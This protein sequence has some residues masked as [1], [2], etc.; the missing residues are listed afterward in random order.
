MQR[1]NSIINF[2]APNIALLVSSINYK[3]KSLINELRIRK[4]QPLCAVINSKNYYIS[5]S[6][7]L[8]EGCDNAY[9]CTGQDVDDTF[10]NLTNHSVYAYE[11]QISL[12]YLPLPFGNRAGLSGN[13]NFVDGNY[14][15]LN[16][17]G[18]CIRIAREHKGCAKELIPVFYNEDS[19]CS[20]VLISPPGGGKT[21]MLR[22]LARCLS[23]LGKRVCVI[24][25]R[26]EIAGLHKGVLAMEL[27]PNTDVISGSKKE[28]GILM[29]VRSL[30]PDVLIFDELTTSKQAQAVN[31]ALN[32]GVAAI[33]SVHSNSIEKALKRP[34]LTPL[35]LSGAL[36]VAVLLKGA[37]EPGRIIEISNLKDDKNENNNSH[38]GVPFADSCGIF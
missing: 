6:G 26:G 28:D 4:G 33:M 24:D 12:G 35:V 16:P 31:D 2:L 25:E 20:G 27:G 22:E 32:C 36:D 5:N 11:D 10:L 19:I 30:S 17:Y 34:Q 14:R 18:I 38:N 8:L 9:I 29:A 15:L 1:I 3:Y 7:S 13:L 37:V 23:V 21:S